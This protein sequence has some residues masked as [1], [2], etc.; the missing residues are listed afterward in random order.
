MNTEH[1]LRINEGI[2]LGTVKFLLL[3]FLIAIVLYLTQLTCDI[4][5]MNRLFG[6]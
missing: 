6:R 5:Q 3:T 2:F 1:F 4:R